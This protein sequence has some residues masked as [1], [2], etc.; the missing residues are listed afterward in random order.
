[1]G[2]TGNGTWDFSI[3]LTTAHESTI[4]SKLSLNKQKKK[5]KTGRGTQKQKQEKENK[6]GIQNRIE[7]HRFKVV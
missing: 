3:I 7:K 5:K 2:E 1:M 4:V 6:K